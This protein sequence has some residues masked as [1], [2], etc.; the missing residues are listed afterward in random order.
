MDISQSVEISY[1]ADISDL[2]K[3]LESLPGVTKESAGKMAKEFSKEMKE[4]EKATKRAASSNSK[5][6]QKISRDTK[7]A[8][9]QFRQM[10]RSANEIGRGLGDLAIIFGDVDSPLGD[11]VNKTAMLGIAAG[12][13]LPVFGHLRTAVV[14]LGV[15]SAAATGGLTLLAGVA[16]GLIF[17][18]GGANEELEKQK[19]ELAENDKAFKK[20]NDQIEKSKTKVLQLAK[21]VL[22]AR[23]A[24]ASLRDEIELEAL[25]LRAEVDPSLLPQ[26]AQLEE[27]L[28]FKGIESRVQ[29]TFGK[30][31]DAL[32]KQLTEQQKAV[33]AA[34]SAAF[35]SLRS[36]SFELQNI[37]GVIDPSD[38]KTMEK[39]TNE[40]KTQSRIV[41]QADG[42]NF[43][44]SQD[45][46]AR[47]GRLQSA[48]E[49]F[50]Q[51]QNKLELLQRRQKDTAEARGELQ[52]KAIEGLK[53]NFRLEKEIEKSK[54]KQDKS[55][56]AGEDTQERINKLLEIQNEFEKISAGINAGTQTALEKQV[57]ALSAQEDKLIEILEKQ[58]EL[59][60]ND[61]DLLDISKE[62]NMLAQQRVELL[63]QE[64]IKSV[65][66]QRSSRLSLLE[67]EIALTQNKADLEDKIAERH[68]LQHEQL[69]LAFLIRKEELQNAI[70]IAE[71]HAH[72]LVAQDLKNNLAIETSIFQQQA[73][74]L[75]VANVKKL[76]D[77]EKKLRDMQM[78]GIGSV[79]SN[80]HNMTQTAIKGSEDQANADM[81]AQDR[82]FRM[83]QGLAIA[84]IAMDAASGAVNALSQYGPILGPIL[85]GTI[86]ASAGVQSAVVASQKPPSASAHMG[87]AMAPDERVIRV[88]TGEAVLDRQ[89]VQSMGGEPGIR[90]MQQGQNK[91]NIVVLN[92]FKHFDKYNKSA[93]RMRS[94]KQG[95]GRY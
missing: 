12:S 51:E 73:D 95:S 63:D 7:K 2:T 67:K 88:L 19:K 36:T 62:L 60:Q 50:G 69:R 56:E 91:N 46:L 85:A 48:L 44:V 71:H 86:A 27:Q 23:N 92:T 77:E 31:S 45:E 6:M 38:V 59:H 78:G 55:D 9:N 5:S 29:G 89:T 53:E 20:Y 25:R 32:D 40:L 74:A 28:A 93:R 65:A 43:S 76:Q 22:T 35:T 37:I 3:Q 75:R 49:K 90:Q 94:T 79:I 52:R 16:A 21:G 33:Q 81:Q 39:I 68:A 61:F 24:I 34:R 1:T 26:L 13:I 18:F 14:G 4:T 58:H 30:L 54:D 70:A 87:Q 72:D 17:S 8:S 66:L 41:V 15:S 42:K 83:Q 82:L 10:K 80:L 11:L 47:S 57:Q 64:N 84:K